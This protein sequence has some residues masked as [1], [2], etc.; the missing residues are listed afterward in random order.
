MPCA[1][2]DAAFDELIHAPLRLWICS[3]L[4]AA[5]S[6]AFPVVRDTLEITD[7]HLSK[8]VKLL[9]DAGYVRSDKGP[10]LAGGGRQIL[11]LSLTKQGK[12]AFAAHLQALKEMLPPV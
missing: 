11:W 4:A 3:I 12:R 10:P 2:A 1:V 8:Q 7:A 6:V 5:D 9:S